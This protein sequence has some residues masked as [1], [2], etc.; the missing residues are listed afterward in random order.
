MRRTSPVRTILMVAAVLTGTV[1]SL[2][3][4]FNSGNGSHPAQLSRTA[5]AGSTSAE[6]HFSPFENI[7]HID[8][9]RLDSAQRTVDIAMYAFTDRYLAEELVTLARRGVRVRIYRDRQQYEEEQHN[10]QRRNQRRAPTYVLNSRK[11]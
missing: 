6:Q 3:S 11:Q 10:S 7:E 8:R 5:E 1:I 2:T 9:D 4:Y